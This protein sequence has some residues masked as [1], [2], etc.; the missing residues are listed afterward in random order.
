MNSTWKLGKILTLD[1]RK[2]VAT[3]QCGGSELIRSIN[4]LYP[5]E[6]SSENTST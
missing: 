5:L 6:M 1:H 4:F 2:A 3:V